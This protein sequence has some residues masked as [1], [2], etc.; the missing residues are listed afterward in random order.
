SALLTA[1]SAVLSSASPCAR[2]VI[3]SPRFLLICSTKSRYSACRSCAV[4]IWACRS[5]SISSSPRLTR[6]PGLTRRTITSVPGPAPGPDPLRR[7]TTTGWLRTGSTEP[8][9]RSATPLPATRAGG[10]SDCRDVDD[11]PESLATTAAG[12]PFF[13]QFVAHDITADR[14]AL[15][16]HVDP[17]RLRNARSPQLNLECLY[18]DG[19]VGHPFLFRRDDP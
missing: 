19:P 13:G 6:V 18:G 12:W 11:S 3:C 10:L 16:S 17:S 4:L 14:S 1:F 8:C 5:N 15:G 2:A 9:K 7:G